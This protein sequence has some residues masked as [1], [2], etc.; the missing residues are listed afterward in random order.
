M[1]FLLEILK[2][3]EPRQAL[4]NNRVF[5]RVEAEVDKLGFPEKCA[6]MFSLT[7]EEYR[8]TYEL[9]RQGKMPESEMMLGRM[10]NVLFG[11]GKKH[12]QTDADTKKRF[13]VPDVPDNW[14]C[15]LLFIKVGHS[16]T[17]STD[18]RRNKDLSGCYIIC[19]AGYL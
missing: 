1:D 4:G 10:L 7:D 2:D 17:G 13:T 9:I 8:P 19:L 11:A 16:I 15:Q 14:V 6:R 18:T 5:A 3:R 12:L